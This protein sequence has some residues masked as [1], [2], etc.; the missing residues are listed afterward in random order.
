MVE[1]I[2]SRRGGIDYSE[3]HITHY[4]RQ[5]LRQLLTEAQATDVTVEGYMFL[6]PFTAALAWR[7]ADIIE[8]LEPAALVNRFG[9]LLFASGTKKDGV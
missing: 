6:A 7:L 5:N 3:Q 1:K 8:A 9:L 2:V 4:D